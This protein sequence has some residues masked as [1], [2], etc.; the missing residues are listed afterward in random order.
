ML[1]RSLLLTLTLLLAC[2]EDAGKGGADDSAGVDLSSITPMEVTS[3]VS[4]E[5]HTVVIVTWKTTEPTQGYVEFGN[6]AAYGLRTPLTES[7]TEHRMLLLGLHANTEAHF[8][9]ITVPESGEEIA[10]D[11]YSITTLSLPSELPALTITGEVKGWKGGYQVLPLQGTGYATAI[12]DDQGE[13]VWY[14]VLDSDRN[15]MDAIISSDRQ[16]VII[17][18]TTAGGEGGPVEPSLFRMTSMDGYT[19]EDLIVEDMDHDFTQLP[20]NTF[21]AI[22]L[23]REDG[24]TGMADSIVEIDREGTKT[25]IWN[26]WDDPNLEAFHDPNKMNW[27]HANGLDYYPDQDAYYISL[28]E[29]GTIVKVDR[30]TGE[31]QWYINGV[32]NEFTFDKPEEMVMLQHQF[33]VQPGGLLVFDNGTEATGYS[34]AV[35]YTLDE[36]ALTAEVI[37]EYERVPPL[38]IFAKGDVARFSD[39]STQVVWS[40]SGEIQN[41]DPDGTVHWQLN[42]ELGYAITFVQVVDSLYAE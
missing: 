11:D 28:K 10:T 19:T 29:L 1:T 4:T 27:S 21:A 34:R 6:D 22:V 8:R 33:E 42:T 24:Q 26:A 13:Y 40:S 5:V 3:E 38:N 7:A 23:A 37:W 25:E 20:D 18:L 32:G 14:S 31:S 9:V 2:S 15:V 41:V 12:I 35:E 36:E 16:E 17:C 39:G 30:A